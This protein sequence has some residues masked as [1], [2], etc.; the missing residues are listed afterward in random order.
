LGFR[1]DGDMEHVRAPLRANA[2]NDR[3]K[4]CSEAIS[5]AFYQVVSSAVLAGWHE[6]EVAIALADIAE[7]FVVELYDRKKRIR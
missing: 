5:V 3:S 6:H 4:D 7:D 1:L 2:H